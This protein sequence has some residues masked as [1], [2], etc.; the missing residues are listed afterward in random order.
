[1]LSQFT[2][3]Y[4]FIIS[5]NLTGMKKIFTLTLL[6][7]ICSTSWTQIQTI[8]EI[9]YDNAG[10][11]IGEFVEVFFQDPQPAD[12]SMYYILLYNGSNGNTYNT[13]TLDLFTATPLNGGLGTYYHLAISGIQNGAPDGIALVGPGGMVIE[14][15]SYEGTMTANNGAAAGMTS[16]EISSESGA[17]GIGT[18]MQNDGFGNWSTGLPETPGAPN[19]NNSNTLLPIKL[20]AFDVQTR[21]DINFI[22]WTTGSEINNDYFEVLRSQNGKSFNSIGEVNGKGN[23]FSNIDYSFEDEDPLNGTSYYRLKQIDFD[24]KFEYSDIVISRNKTLNAAIYPTTTSDFISIDLEADQG[25]TLTI[26]N[27]I[28]QVV[29]TVLLQDTNNSINISALNKGVYYIRID[30]QGARMIQKISKF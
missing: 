27:N 21:N 28:G 13:I 17:T 2:Q 11:D 29:K 15:L 19:L 4:N 30:N 9:H 18:S 10:G 22:F 16:T 24:G 14:F 3:N 25:S 5:L 20:I 12:L 23:S 7:F 8:T 1:M 26:Y 6:L